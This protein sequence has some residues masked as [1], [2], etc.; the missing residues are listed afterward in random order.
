M[1]CKGSSKRRVVADISAILVLFDF[2]HDLLAVIRAGFGANRLLHVGSIPSLVHVLVHVFDGPD[3]V[4]HFHVK[5]AVVLEQKVRVVGDH[6][7]VV[8]EKG[9]VRE[10]GMPLGDCAPVIRPSIQGVR[11]LG[12]RGVG[13]DGFRKA[14]VACLLLQVPAGGVEAWS[15]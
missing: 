13:L 7:F 6:P 10:G 4:A 12:N 11:V 15:A 1:L 8:E 2:V 3:A 14:L 9:G 5:V